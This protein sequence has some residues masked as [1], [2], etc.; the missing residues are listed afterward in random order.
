MAKVVALIFSLNCL[1]FFSYA[2]GDLGLYQLNK[3]LPQSNNLNPAFMP[4]HK[5]V[6]GFPVISSTKVFVD[7]D[8]LSFND[9]FAY[10]IN[11]NL[12]L[13]TLGLPGKVKDIQR[14]GASTELGLFYFGLRGKRSYFTFTINHVTDFRFNYSGDLVRWGILGPADPRIAG[15]D[16]EIENFGLKSSSYHEIGIGYSRQFNDKLT[17]GARLKY[18]QGH[19]IVETKEISGLIHVGSD[20][21]TVASGNIL[22]NTAG[23]ALEDEN[24]PDYI[25]YFTNNGNRGA[26]LDLGATFALND[27]LTLSASVKDLGFINWSDYTRSYELDPITYTYRGFDLLDLINKNPNDQFL[28]AEIDS[29]E[30]LY[31]MS[32]TDDVSFSSAL[33]PK[34]YLGANYLLGK[35]HNVGALVY[36]DFFKGHI[37]PSV[38]LSY[39][40]KLGRILNMV[41]NTAYVNGEF[42]GF[43]AGFTLKLTGMQVYTSTDHVMSAI[44]PSRASVAE[45][46]TGVNFVFGRVKKPEIEEEKEEV[47][48]DEPE[49]VMTEEE[50]I[51][52]LDDDEEVATD[53]VTTD[54]IA[55]T[56][57]VI[58]EQEQPL[59]TVQ[60]EIPVPVEED[61]LVEA[62]EEELTEVYDDINERTIIQRGSD[63]NELAVGHYVIVGVFSQIDNARTY[64]ERLKQAGFDN[65]FG[66]VSKRNAY[67]IHVKTSDNL[68]EVRQ[69]RDEVRTLDQFQFPD[70][71]VLSMID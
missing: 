1:I 67:Y 37:N 43:G 68:Q 41:V 39:N 8:G 62:V 57:P 48:E 54:T 12:I 17:L 28:Q 9:Y 51:E 23:I 49:D 3:S 55:T 64:S 24:D 34:T 25:N 53:T 63:P 10:D 32:E 7:N 35:R 50:F 45:V 42:T 70:A 20:S 6:I 21:V 19:G 61:E 60:S 59:D 33:R 11:D 46:H 15:N 65:D 16:L 13:D 47:E 69:I 29:V 4:E 56:P 30:S 27:K 44:Y 52:S 66:Y 31:N 36:F 5:V 2:Q 18:L 38:A 71:W 58:E 26:A 40:L 14:F 22:V